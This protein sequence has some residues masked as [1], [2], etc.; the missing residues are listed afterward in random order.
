MEVYAKF[1]SNY[2]YELKEIYVHIIDPPRKIFININPNVEVNTYRW[3]DL[4]SSAKIKSFEEINEISTDKKKMLVNFLF[5]RE[6]RE[7]E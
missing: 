3:V 5:E 4:T 7:L 6:M 2:S 1:E